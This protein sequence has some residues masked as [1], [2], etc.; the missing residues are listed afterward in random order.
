[1]SFEIIAML[2]ACLSA[3]IS[4]SAAVL[5]RKARKQMERDYGD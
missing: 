1:M 2:V 4:V 5:T 3:V